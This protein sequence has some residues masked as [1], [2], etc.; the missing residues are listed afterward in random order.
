MY[1]IRSYYARNISIVYSPDPLITPESN[2]KL[3]KKTQ[4]KEVWFIPVRVVNND[5]RAFVPT[6]ENIEVIADFE[7]ADIVAREE[8]YPQI[9]YKAL[10]CFIWL[11]AGLLGSFSYSSYNF[12]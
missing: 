11:G 10:P 12:V 2:H 6:S 4:R 8:Y 9:K 1:A 7:R 3:Y 5:T